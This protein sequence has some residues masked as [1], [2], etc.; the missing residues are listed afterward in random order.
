MQMLCIAIGIFAGLA[1]LHVL[2]S[3]I[4]SHVDRQEC[5]SYRDG[6]TAL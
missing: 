1:L 5:L 3:C 4:A 2:D 6:R